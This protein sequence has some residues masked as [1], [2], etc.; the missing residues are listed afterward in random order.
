MG[1]QYL[2]SIA[3][4]LLQVALIPGVHASMGAKGP[5]CFTYLSG[6]P[7]RLGQAFGWELVMTFLLCA[8]E[9]AD[10]LAG[11]RGLATTVGGDM[12][13]ACD[14]LLTAVVH[15]VAI[16]KPG[17]GNVGPLA[18]GYTL[19]A[20]AFIGGPM[21]GTALNP[22][23]V[24]APTLVYNCYWASLLPYMIGEY[25]GGIICGILMLPLYGPGPE[26]TSTLEHELL[27]AQAELAQ[28]PV[29]GKTE[30]QG[31]IALQANSGGQWEARF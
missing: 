21:T 26:F 3:G 10:E 25:I 16:S 1:S 5:G 17:F 4:A 30:R 2:G 9:L 22:A 19:F 11:R 6:E 29:G 13:S 8:G 24:F 23:R 18:I 14:M 7:V 12:I 28:L 27:A 31:L 15:A 20:S